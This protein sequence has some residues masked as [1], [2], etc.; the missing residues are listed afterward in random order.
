MDDYVQE[1]TTGWL[2]TPGDDQSFASAVLTALR[3]EDELPLMGAAAAAHVRQFHTES[4]L[5][6]GISKLAELAS[7]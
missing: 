2:A 7:R 5:A 4:T 3:N 6:R 1:G